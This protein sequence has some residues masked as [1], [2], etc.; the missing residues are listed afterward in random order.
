M[1]IPLKSSSS[2]TRCINFNL[3]EQIDLSP[4]LIPLMRSYHWKHQQAEQACQRYLNFLCLLWLYPDRLL[5]PTQE[6]DQVW[7]N[8][9]LSTRQYRQDCQ[10][11]F[12]CYLDH[13]PELN[14]EENPDPSL[15]AAFQQT[16]AL[17]ER[18]F[19]AGSFSDSVTNGPSACN[20]L[21][22]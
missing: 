18:H 13:H 5:I 11:L 22:L 16:K 1:A 21:R 14:L 3:L 2:V 12:G 15:L 4:L 19:G 6:I 10:T 7:H 9:I 20:P 8:H 17:F